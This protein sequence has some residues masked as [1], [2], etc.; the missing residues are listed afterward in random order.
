MDVRSESSKS[1]RKRVKQRISEKGYYT[2]MEEGW[3]DWEDRVWKREEYILETF[4]E[5]LW[6]RV[7]FRGKA[8]LEMRGYNGEGFA[9]VEWSQGIRRAFKLDIEYLTLLEE[10]LGERKG[11]GGAAL[12]NFFCKLVMEINEGEKGMERAEEGKKGLW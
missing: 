6:E 9:L 4:G 3:V 1:S 11:Q 2:K 7:K 5:Y 12:A 8:E 10:K